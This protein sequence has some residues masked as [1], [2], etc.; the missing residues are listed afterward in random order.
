MTAPLVPTGPL[1]TPEL[2]RGGDIKPARARDHPAWRCRRSTAGPGLPTRPEPPRTRRRRTPIPP[3]PAPDHAL[4]ATGLTNAEGEA[5]SFSPHDFRRIFV[6]DA[7]MNGLPP[8][9][10]R[11]IRGHKS[12][13][14]T[15]GYTAVYPAE[16]TEADRAFMAR[17]RASHPG[18]EYRIPTEEEWDAFL[19]HFEKRKVSIGTCARA[20]GSPASMST[21]VSDARSSDQIRPNGNGLPRST[22]ISS[23][24]SPKPGA[25]AGSGTLWGS[26]SASL[27][28]RPNSPELDS[29]PPHPPG[30]ARPRRIVSD[31][32]TWPGPTNE[33]G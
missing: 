33:K 29:R 4:A 28:Q 6:T 26:W 22:T 7:I 24:V 25:K 20:F 11:V 18:E 30:H 8:H 5:L 23:P 27:E 13:D 14:T 17:R 21:L 15:I 19:A 10:A 2:G 1:T 9:I 32:I 16:T 12:I 31:T 3:P